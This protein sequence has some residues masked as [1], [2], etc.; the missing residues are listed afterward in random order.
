MWPFAS[1][2]PI[3][4]D[5]GPVLAC[6]RLKGIDTTRPWAVVSRTLKR[7]RTLTVP[8]TVSLTLSRR[9]PSGGEQRVSGSESHDYGWLPSNTPVKPP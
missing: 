4:A 6:D 3:A 9:I 2:A 5:V 1:G 7:A 8:L